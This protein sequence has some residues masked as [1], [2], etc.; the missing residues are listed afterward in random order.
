M[1]SGR[2]LRGVLIGMASRQQQQQAQNEAGSSAMLPKACHLQHLHSHHLTRGSG[3]SQF[4]WRPSA[5]VI[6]RPLGPDLCL[7][8]NT[9]PWLASPT[10]F[11]PPNSSTSVDE[12]RGDGST[13]NRADEPR[14]GPADFRGG[15]AGAVPAAQL[16]SAEGA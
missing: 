4:A 16:H 12:G 1:L 14:T 13:D 7:N 2:G 5:D 15:Q 9:H 3:A 11:A 10:I 8:A 6:T